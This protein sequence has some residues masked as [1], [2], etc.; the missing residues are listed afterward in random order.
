[1]IL[2]EKAEGQRRERARTCSVASSLKGGCCER[3]AVP[4]SGMPPQSWNPDQIGTACGQSPARTGGVLISQVSPGSPTLSSLKA[5]LVNRSLRRL[6]G[7]V[8]SHLY[9]LLGA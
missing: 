3:P 5:R 1:M 4:P 9:A 7:V 8:P 6:D 2:Q